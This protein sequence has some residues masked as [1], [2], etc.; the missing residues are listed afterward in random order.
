MKG[1][2]EYKGFYA[3]HNHMPGSG[4][5]LQVSGTVVFITGGWSC[6]LRA[7]EGNTGT[8]QN[9]LSLDLVLEPPEP[10]MMVPQVLTPCEVS[11]SVDDPAIDYRQVSFR[12][13]GSEDEPP[14]T[15]DIDHPE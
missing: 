9:M 12:V 8:N 4:R 1:V 10:G 5:R 2:Y 14:R 7:T 11:W 3:S 6:S 13:I 15:L